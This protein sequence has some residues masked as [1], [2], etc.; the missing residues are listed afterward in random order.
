MT[1]IFS[2][3]LL[4]KDKPKST[5][6]EGFD[7]RKVT[8]PVKE[9][10]QV[11]YYE[12]IGTDNFGTSFYARQAYEVDAGRQQEPILYLPIYDVTEDANLPRSIPIDRIGPGSIIFEEVTEGGETVFGTIGGSSDSIL[13]HHYAAGIE[14]SKDLVVYNELWNIAI[15]ER[16]AGIAYN[17]LQNDVH[18]RPF[19]TFAYTPANQTPASAVGTGIVEH[20]IRTI[21][22][23]VISAQQDTTNPRNG[24]YVLL[25]APGD[26]PT[27]TRALSPVPQLGTTVASVMGSNITTIIAYNGW[28][29]TRGKKTV[30]YPGVT[31][32]K[33][34]LIDV[35][36]RGRYSRSFV[37]QGLLT[38]MGNPDVSRFILEQSIYDCYFTNFVDV[39]AI[40]EEITLP[41]S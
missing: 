29:G 21:D 15:V 38:A 1:L 19:L 14:Y 27:I 10:G 31:T 8:R 13:M 32:G 35:G 30:T 36:N 22:D 23:A 25:C 41:T 9:N 6:R 12:F 4:S 39:A 24:P 28:T 40:A 5:F 7:L 20:Y 33:A 11:R 2:K 34:Y 18:L 17:A 16:A 26:L 37:K 3:A